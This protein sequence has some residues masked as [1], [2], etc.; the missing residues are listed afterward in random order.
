MR[1]CRPGLGA[2]DGSWSSPRAV[3]GAAACHKEQPGPFQGAAAGAASAARRA[4]AHLAVEAAVGVALEVDV[5]RRDGKALV[6]LDHVVHTGLEREALHL[7]RGGRGGRGGRGIRAGGLARVA[8][9][10]TASPR[11]CG[12]FRRCKW[13][14]AGR[15]ALPKAAPIGGGAGGRVQS[16]TPPPSAAYAPA[17]GTLSRPKRPPESQDHRATGPGAGAARNSMA[18]GTQDACSAWGHAAAAQNEIPGL[19]PRPSPSQRCR[20]AG[21]RAERRRSRW[22]GPWG[23]PR[24]PWFRRV[25]LKGPFGALSRPAG[26]AQ[27]PP[28]PR[29][30]PFRRLWSGLHES[31]TPKQSYPNA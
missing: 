25:L 4:Q 7:R 31:K 9:R 5:A 29:L 10:I 22:P 26:G 19:A 30:G 14:N 16:G 15:G 8:R 12:G 2:A 1:A 17:A 11:P 6:E 3:S 13:P 27:C 23:A 18:C 28:R 20:P 21:G 24:C